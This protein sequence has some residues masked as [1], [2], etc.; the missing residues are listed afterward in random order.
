MGVDTSLSPGSGLFPVTAASAGG[1][2]SLGAPSSPA[3]RGSHTAREEGL[4]VVPAGSF[5]VDELKTL[6]SV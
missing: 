5:L 4:G 2:R 3:T 1:P 6:K